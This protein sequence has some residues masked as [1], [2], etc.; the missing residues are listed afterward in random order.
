MTQSLHAHTA[1]HTRHHI[2]HACIHLQQSVDQK[3]SQEDVSELPDRNVLDTRRELYKHNQPGRLKSNELINN[4]QFNDQYLKKRAELRKDLIDSDIARK[5]AAVDIQKSLSSNKNP[6]QTFV[7]DEH[8]PLNQIKLKLLQEEQNRKKNARESSD[9]GQQRKLLVDKLIGTGNQKGRSRITVLG[10]F[11]ME[12]Y[13]EAQKMVKEDV[14]VKGDAMKNFQF[15][16]IASDALAPDRYLKDYR[17][18]K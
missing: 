5:Q 9:T 1:Q 17:N 16:Q 10:D 12:S 4:D 7:S 6:K 2:H 3:S 8:N 15:N 14:T 18:S 11:N 13:L